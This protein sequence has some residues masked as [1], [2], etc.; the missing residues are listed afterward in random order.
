M[1]LTH[2]V[3]FEFMPGA[4]GF[5]GNISVLDI[6]SIP[7]SRFSRRIPPDKTIDEMRRRLEELR[8]SDMKEGIPTAS[9]GANFDVFINDAGQLRVKINGKIYRFDG[10]LE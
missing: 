4:G 3:F 10:T 7:G 9:D 5:S 2:L 1:I 8:Q 6:P